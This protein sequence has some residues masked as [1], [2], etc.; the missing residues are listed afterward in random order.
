MVGTEYGHQG[1]THTKD[2]F[3]LC[4]L[5]TILCCTLWTLEGHPECVMM[6]QYESKLLYIHLA[7]T[8]ACEVFV[9]KY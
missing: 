5:P 8:Q 9:L 6:M 2:G 4:F 3:H 7:P 1:A